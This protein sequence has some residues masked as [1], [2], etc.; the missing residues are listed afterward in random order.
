MERHGLERVLLRNQ[1]YWEN[2]RALAGT[3]SLLLFSLLLLAGFALYQRY[4]WPRPKY[5][6]T[7]PDGRPIPVIPL[8]LPFY[9]N[10]A[11]VQQWASQTVV[12]IYSLDYVTW[13]KTL[14][15]AEVYFTPTG[16]QD[17]LTA[18]KASNNL[19]A[20]KA[21]KQVVSAEVTAAPTLTRQGQLSSTVP[22]SWDLQMPVTVTYQN[23]N[24][25]IIKQVGI[26]LMQVQ[27]A[28][29]LRY[30][31]GIAISQLVFQAK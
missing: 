23:S 2:Y 20:I 18:L 5:F 21:K 6:A 19:E 4:T 10:P 29:L 27:R 3:F 22:Y 31:N 8:D 11:P 14:Q 7:T 24:N 15:D 17:F 9:E 16:Y 13:R 28:S 1:F 30:P 12:A 25:E 26:I